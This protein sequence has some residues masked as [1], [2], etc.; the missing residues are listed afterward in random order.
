MGLHPRLFSIAPTGLSYSSTF[1]VFKKIANNKEDN[2]KYKDDDDGVAEE[3]A[4][5]LDDAGVGSLVGQPSQ[6]RQP[7]KLII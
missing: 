6:K 3:T 2:D 1:A 4:V 7:E 5:T